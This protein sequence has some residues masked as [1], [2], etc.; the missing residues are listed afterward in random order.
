LSVSYVRTDAAFLEIVRRIETQDELCFDCEFHTEGRYFP[1]LCLVQLAF[2]AELW[3]IDPRQVTLAALGPVLESERIR[4]V[5]HD[6]RQDLP[7]L[8]KAAGIA[9]L[10]NVFD[11]QL[12]AAFVGCGTKIGYGALVYDLCDVKLD[13]SLQVSDWSNELSEGQLEYALNDVRYLPKISS[14]L[15]TRLEELG[16]L[17]WAIDACDKATTVALSRP[18][19]EKLYR[20]V[21][22]TS[23]LDPVPLG[24][25]RELAKWRD[26]AAQALNK[27]APTVANDLALKSMA[28]RPP[29]DKRGLETVRGLGIGRNQPWARE[30]FEA[31]KLGEQRPEPNHRREFSKQQEAQID[32]LVSVL[33]IARRYVATDR[34]ISVDLLSD[35]AE[36]RALAEWHL[37]DRPA[38]STFE[39]LSGWRRNVVG[40][41]LLDVLSGKLAFRADAKTPAGIDVIPL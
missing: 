9:S 41:V 31:I 38:E 34:G 7:I 13:K 21:S 15:R 25:L 6:G 20:R 16:R 26:R 3:A 36:L 18:D 4:K 23:Q 37:N 32:G 24:I 35:Q 17:A 11:T 10:R 39:V 28:L 22:S 8:A 5:I 2:G 19:P 30:L 14:I 40:N 29:R 1:H 27:P 12:A 33:S